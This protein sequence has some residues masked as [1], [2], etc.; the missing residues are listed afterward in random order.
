VAEPEPF[1][2]E[3]LNISIPS[4]KYDTDEYYLGLL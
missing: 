3:D 4:L 2:L 1:N